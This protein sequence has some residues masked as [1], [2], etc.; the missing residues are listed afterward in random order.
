MTSKVEAV[1]GPYD[2][3]LLPLPLFDF[4]WTDGK[5]NFRD[6][7]PGRGL[8]VKKRTLNHLYVLIYVENAYVRCS[9]CEVYHSR[10]VEECSLCGASLKRRVWETG[11]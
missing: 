7:K 1:G 6:W 8:Y 4:V 5:R 3:A 9:Q 2:G 10:E 11:L